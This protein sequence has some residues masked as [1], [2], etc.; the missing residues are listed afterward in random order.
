M[1]NMRPGIEL[2]A[3]IAEKVMGHRLFETPS[4]GL[5]EEDDEFNWPLLR[6]SIDIH[7]AWEVV[8]KIGKRF[9]LITQEQ[10]GEAKAWFARTE[11][12]GYPVGFGESPAHA[13]C[14][15]ALRVIEKEKL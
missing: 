14:L 12:E 1:K 15:A 3:L 13:I 6:Y 10:P 5:Y 11:E 7:A 8:E 4:S 2:D 9:C